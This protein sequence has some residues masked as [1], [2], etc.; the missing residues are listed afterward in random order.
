MLL[1]LGVRVLP[2]AARPAWN[3]A[4]TH[5]VAPAYS[6][7]L[8]CVC[9]GAAGAVFVTPAYVAACDAA[10]ALLDPGAFAPDG[11]APRTP[12]LWPGA[13]GLWR[14]VGPP[15]RGHRVAILGELCPPGAA[16]LDSA[17]AEVMLRAA[18]AGVVAVG[19]APTFALAPAMI[20]ED[21]PALRMCV[22]AGVPCLGAAFV[23]DL[24]ACAHVNVVEY[25]SVSGQRGLVVDEISA[26]S[27][28]GLRAGEAVAVTQVGRGRSARARGR[29]RGAGSDQ[30]REL[31]A[32]K[33]SVATA[34]QPQPP[35]IEDAAASEEPVE[36]AQPHA[37]DKDAASSPRKR[38]KRK[39]CSDENAVPLV[40]TRRSKRT[41][42][43]SVYRLDARSLE[44]P[45]EEEKFASV[46]SPCEVV[47][48]FPA[49][50][51]SDT[52]VDTGIALRNPGRD[53][54]T[55]ACDE[56]EPNIDASRAPQID[57]AKV[58][59]CPERSPTLI[60]AG[61]DSSKRP[62]T[63]L[64]SSGQCSARNTPPGQ[65]SSGK[66]FLAQ[67]FQDPTSPSRAAL[68][69]SSPPVVATAEASA[70]QAS[71][72]LRS[73]GR[74]FAPT[75]PLSSTGARDSNADGPHFVDGFEAQEPSQ[76]YVQG[77][78]APQAEL[79]VA[80]SCPMT[81]DADVRP[82]SSPSKPSTSRKRRRVR[83]I[84]ESPPSDDDDDGA[85]DLE[86][87]ASNRATS[88]APVPTFCGPPGNEDSSDAD[89]D[90]LSRPVFPRRLASQRRGINQESI[91]E[92]PSVS[93]TPRNKCGQTDHSAAKFTRSP[94]AVSTPFAAPGVLGDSRRRRIRLRTPA[95]MP[96]AKV[97]SP[98]TGDVDG[99]DERTG[100]AG[101]AILSIQNLD[102]EVVAL[103]SSPEIQL[104]YS[105]ERASV[106]T[107]ELVSPKGSRR[108]SH[109]NDSY[110]SDDVQSAFSLPQGKRDFG[111]PDF[112]P[113]S[114]MALIF[115]A[116]GGRRAKKEVELLLMKNRDAAAE[117]ARLE[118]NEKAE[119]AAEARDSD[120]DVLD[121]V[122]A[123]GGSSALHEGL[124]FQDGQDGM[125]ARDVSTAVGLGVQTEVPERLPVAS[126]SLL[127]PRLPFS[128]LV[129][130]DCVGE[131]S[132]GV[133]V[134]DGLQES[135]VQSMLC[136]LSAE[137][138]CGVEGMRNRITSS[139]LLGTLA[140]QACF[141]LAESAVMPK[142]LSSGCNVCSAESLTKIGGF[143]DRLLQLDPP[144]DVVVMLATE[145]MSVRELQLRES[146][147]DSLHVILTSPR[148]PPLNRQ[149]HLLAVLW[150]QLLELCERSPKIDS[151]WSVFDSV[152]ASLRVANFSESGRRLAAGIGAS[153]AE[154]GPRGCSAR[155]GKSFLT[156]WEQ[157]AFRAAT[158]FG[159][160]FCVKLCE[161]A[162]ERRA[163]AISGHSPTLSLTSPRPPNWKFL[164]SLLLDLKGQISNGSVDGHVDDVIGKR[165]F[166][167]L[168]SM[169]VDVACQLWPADEEVV[170]CAIDAV[171][172][173]YRSRTVDCEC[174]GVPEFLLQLG[175]RSD[176][177]WRRDFLSC[178]LKTPCDCIVALSWLFVADS[179][180]QV[181]AK[182]AGRIVSL[183]SGL[184]HGGRSSG[185]RHALSLILAAADAISPSGSEAS[186][187]E[188]VLCALLF[189]RA[190]SLSK[191]LSASSGIGH[192]EKAR[193]STLLE[194]A[195]LRSRSL[196]SSSRSFVCYLEQAASCFAQAVR[197]LEHPDAVSMETV[198]R[199]EAARIQHILVL[200]ICVELVDTVRK[201]VEIALNLTAND[202]CDWNVHVALLDSIFV[203]TSSVVTQS[204]KL[205]QGILSQ[206]RLPPS[207]SSSSLSR[208]GIL[209]SSMRTLHSFVNLAVVIVRQA[210][211]GGD[212]VIWKDC[213]PGL[214]NF[215][216]S[217]ETCS[218]SALID[219]VHK[220]VVL[221]NPQVA[222]EVRLLSVTTLARVIGLRSLVLGG[223]S[224]ADQF[225][226]PASIVRRCGMDFWS[227][228]KLATRERQR[229]AAKPKPK[230]LQVSS[231][232]QKRGRN[233][234][235]IAVPKTAPN[236][237]SPKLS[238]VGEPQS[239]SITPVTCEGRAMVSSFWSHLVDSS[240]SRYVLESDPD[241]ER[242]VIAVWIVLL[243]A[244]E[245][246]KNCQPVLSLAWSLK[247]ACASRP[248]IASFFRETC[249]HD[250]MVESDPGLSLVVV[251]VR[252]ETVGDALSVCVGASGFFPPDKRCILIDALSL[253]VSQG[254]FDLF[255]PAWKSTTKAT[256]GTKTLTPLQCSLT[257]SAF[258]ADLSALL[259]A[260]RG[261]LGKRH[262]S[263]RG[264]ANEGVD[265][266]FRALET[267]SEALSHIS[268]V[269]GIGSDKPDLRSMY[270]RVAAFVF[271]GAACLGADSRSVEL[272]VRFARFATLVGTASFRDLVIPMR[273][274]KL[275]KWLLHLGL[276][277]PYRVDPT[278]ESPATSHMLRCRRSAGEQWRMRA[279]H[280]L[281]HDPLTVTP[282][283][284]P[285]YLK[286]TER[287]LSVL[288]VHEQVRSSAAEVSQ[289]VQAAL[290]KIV[291]SL[292]SS[293][294]D[295]AKKRNLEWQSDL[296]KTV[297]VCQQVGFKVEAMFIDSANLAPE[298][299][300]HGRALAGLGTVLI[301]EAT[302]ILMEDAL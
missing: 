187:K 294:S 62:S 137:R 234:P 220:G 153:P 84:S 114:A 156:D 53:P 59:S 244:P 107:A 159:S 126:S 232:Q 212:R 16:V 192:D 100:D 68:T 29:R 246:V 113:A 69:K 229:L 282:F 214:H 274:W 86:K 17:T 199:R 262:I 291:A 226:E 301:A 124:T 259:F 168:H 224:P 236:R 233:V 298:D 7:S 1:R 255:N 78:G 196:A 13:A 20:A 129:G 293:G 180:L 268:N 218:L 3:P 66:V 155:R 169:V 161:G 174:V 148:L 251:K 44:S 210:S 82:P 2:A 235:L 142:L 88:D 24:L 119:C 87:S 173:F 189:S 110:I 150:A 277:A 258:A 270:G 250:R 15:L 140:R 134:D 252:P 261:A 273:H 152:A 12:R 76:I 108:G 211:R 237:T 6:R 103:E 290:S 120:V 178:H 8:L 283:G 200:E 55:R 125:I 105:P 73:S 41:V 35:G 225:L 139:V 175:S 27:Y 63:Q 284:S 216:E 281:V 94:G 167:L 40:A 28:D 286:A 47:D 222:E 207:V 32:G 198:S 48:C 292:P 227:S 162:E 75:A 147:I 56:C 81:E 203:A 112:S 256:T 154:T 130:I 42:C 239:L 99:G 146:D 295:A 296:S 194:A 266:G 240:W 143:C 30:E 165:L 231:Q 238:G 26:A 14:R 177:Q 101:A 39:V 171:H 302:A 145:L 186:S 52:M 122:P 54:P 31:Q 288:V 275:P 79:G 215:L 71:G 247:A 157:W 25:L 49:A 221:D 33:M 18:G 116:I 85:V 243:S 72:F 241:L 74:A 201:L 269:A 248:V 205:V 67:T 158:A 271:L 141:L 299:Q 102:D 51:V 111:L 60:A 149:H 213:F 91:S 179:Q 257:H 263:P 45:R 123:P 144:E 197:V 163:S 280:S 164:C 98:D 185:Y 132:V 97:L 95:R 118:R 184:G 202:E 92:A 22:D 106:E 209:V 297:D 289:D 36:V 23:P 57:V 121:R 151:F 77:P 181:T 50:C 176:V 190:P 90:A 195:L 208:R 10:G 5:V 219:I 46:A 109:Q 191:A 223:V 64:P 21:D 160:L 43:P 127:L 65:A 115:D 11:A 166:E 135:E 138:V 80:T 254:G 265:A 267:V 264:I 300:A 70:A 19:D 228:I 4:V 83:V 253:V 278:T 170:F 193:W 128:V 117:A 276:P 172:S 249:L 89:D 285:S 182:V 188:K 206:L 133:S 245:V 61:L 38:K 260:V 93:A 279:L 287:L 34:A 9:G 272:R 230:P 136:L 104:E 58:S 183:S 96:V 217:L 37:R 131:R 242:M 204:G